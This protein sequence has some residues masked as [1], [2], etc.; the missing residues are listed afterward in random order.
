MEVLIPILVGIV[1][2]IVGA[3]LGLQY[4]KTSSKGKL[5]LANEEA[6]RVL[7]DAQKQAEGMRKEALIEAKEEILKQR[8]CF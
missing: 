8:H 3:L 5:K 2:I 4:A 6:S 7:D 1:A